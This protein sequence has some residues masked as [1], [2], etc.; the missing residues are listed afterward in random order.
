LAVVTLSMDDPSEMDPVRAQLLTSGAVGLTNLIS[1]YGSGSQSA[2]AFEVP[3][4]ALPHYKLYDRSGK[5]RRTF[6]LDPSAKHQFTTAD[7]DAAVAK[8]LAE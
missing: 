2:E 1:E 5:L 4:G 6:G 8:L 7:V 3:G